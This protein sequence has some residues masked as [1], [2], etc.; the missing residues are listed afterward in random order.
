MIYRC[1]AVGMFGDERNCC[2]FA[3]DTLGGDYWSIMNCIITGRKFVNEKC[4]KFMS[5]KYKETYWR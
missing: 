5:K 4:S 1:M 2:N 3:G